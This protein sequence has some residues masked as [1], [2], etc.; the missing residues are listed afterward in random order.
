MKGCGRNTAGIFSA[1]ILLLA[2]AGTALAAPSAGTIELSPFVGIGGFDDDTNLEAGPAFGARAGYWLTDAI[3]AEAAVD[4][5]KTEVDFNDASASVLSPHADLLYNFTRIGH[6][7]FIPFV[8]A[9]AG[10][11]RFDASGSKA[12]WDPMVNV[13][14]GARYLITDLVGLRADLRLPVTYDATQT[15]YLAT[16][17]VSFLLGAKEQAMAPA[18]APKPMPAPKPAPVDSDHDGVVDSADDCPGTPAGVKVDASGCPLDS[19]HDGVYDS[20]DK[21]PGTP[22]G[23]IVD[24][25][26]CSLRKVSITL[27]VEF[28]T[29]KSIVKPEYDQEL[30]QFATFLKKYPKTTCEIGGHTD[31]IGSAAS[32]K[33][34]S[35][36]RADAVRKALIE[37]FDIDGA[38]LTAKGYGPDR[39]IA[40]NGTAEGRQKNRRIEAEVE[41]QIVE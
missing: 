36:A 12:D 21:C 23:A 4:Y 34:L 33:T 39:P 18:P 5:V 16:I 22:E 31:N 28:D 30:Q 25:K 24:D 14:V 7:E 32:N 13:G 8:A 15:H 17:G 41:S 11:S 40:D 10:A 9:G 38:R 2:A 26:G 3:S 6:G 27:N 19:D 1:I 20:A 37:R 29:G 35:Q